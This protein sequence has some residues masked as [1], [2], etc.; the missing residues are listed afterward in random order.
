MF[1]YQFFI[2]F[3]V[4]IIY[5]VYSKNKDHFDGRIK[6][7]GI[8]QCGRY[9]TN[10]F[11]CNGFAYDRPKN[12]CYLSKYPIDKHNCASIF[13]DE[14]KGSQTKCDKISA[15]PDYYYGLMTER[16]RLN[17]I[18]K[19]KSN[20]KAKT[21]FKK[22]VNDKIE[23][24]DIKEIQNIPYEHYIMQDTIWPVNKQDFILRDKLVK[25]EENYINLH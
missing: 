16:Q 24:I 17:M 13:I 5:I 15:I 9:C 1:N 12:T 22:I 25:P 8:E 18:Y 3:I 19:C 11:G 7:I 10:L 4:T 21:K 20:D 23:N 14:Y 6:N 2:F